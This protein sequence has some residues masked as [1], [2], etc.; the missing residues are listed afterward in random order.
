MSVDHEPAEFLLPHPR[1]LEALDAHL[2]G[3]EV[4]WTTIDP[5]EA[6]AGSRRAAEGVGPE[7]GLR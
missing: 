2:M 5:D 7:D 6:A 1:L 3:N 4:G